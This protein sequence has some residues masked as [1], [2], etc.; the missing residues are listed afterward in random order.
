MEHK[1]NE[2]AFGTPTAHFESFIYGSWGRFSSANGEVLYLSTQVNLRG[3]SDHDRR[4]MDAVAPVRESLDVR[5]LE[6][7]ELL[8]R[9]LDDYRVLTGLIP[10]LM[11]GSTSEDKD[12]PNTRFFPPILAIVLPFE[13]GKPAEFTGSVNVDNL[14]FLGNRFSG[15]RSGSDFQFTMMT[16]EG[17]PRRDL[18]VGR[19]DWNS[20]KTRLVIIDGQHRA[21]ALLALYRSLSKKNTWSSVGAS[22]A[23]YKHFYDEMIKSRYGSSE[24]P[25]IELPITICVL[26]DLLGAEQGEKLHKSARRLFVDVNKEAKPPNESRLVLLSETN[27]K[28]IF[29][30]TLL[31]EVRTPAEKGMSYMPLSAIEYDSPNANANN[32][33]AQKATCI[34]DVSIL[35]LIVT[36][37][38]WGPEVLLDDIS[39]I[40]QRDKGGAAS[41]MRRQLDLA[42]EDDKEF[43]YSHNGEQ[44]TLEISKLTHS[45]FPATALETLTERFIKLWGSHLLYILA[46]AEPFKSF[47]EELIV[48]DK[49]WEVLP[50]APSELAKEALLDGVGTYFTLKKLMTDEQLSD[51]SGTDWTIAWKIVQAREKE[52]R[53]KL[54]SNYAMTSDE[55]SDDYWCS[56]RVLDRA[57]TN[58][59]QIAYVMAF[60]SLN[61]CF[62]IG[63]SDRGTFATTYVEAINNYMHSFNSS[64]TPRRFFW[65]DAETSRTRSGFIALTQK[66]QKDSWVYF[67]WLLIQIF[68]FQMRANRSSGSLPE[69]VLRWFDTHETGLEELAG[70]ARQ[71][72]VNQVV[73]ER[74]KALHGK[75]TPEEEA[76]LTNSVHDDLGKLYLDWFEMDIT[77]IFTSPT[78][79]TF[80]EDDDTETNDDGFED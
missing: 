12:S 18:R 57:R 33:Q 70:K 1:S 38:I 16:S 21:M 39:K 56:T 27:L 49:S 76:K 14:E 22:A 77:A 41:C 11:E 37:L 19:L 67:R 46:N 23:R 65:A 71:L 13:N 62:N 78:L 51:F 58:A 40:P 17:K 63:E 79:S 43:K 29:A 72:Y 69:T 2:F 9:D 42:F 54:R 64:G 45:R 47:S 32:P 24:L 25:N 53:S 10:Y 60:D 48:F 26:P 59:L 31:D 73:K 80:G 3:D 4:L 52:F 66:T 36:R 15:I 68:A 75:S 61:K 35:Q 28:D 50:D 55:D 34:T 5:E 20:A 7:S 6:F 44:L 30:R 8:Q 74:L